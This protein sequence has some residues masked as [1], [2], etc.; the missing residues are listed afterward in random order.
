M[1][2]AVSPNANM[3]TSSIAKGS[4]KYGEVQS[5]DST[6]YPQNGFKDGYWY[7]LKQS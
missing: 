2:F 1:S 6:A 4:Y 7:V 5:T 3:L